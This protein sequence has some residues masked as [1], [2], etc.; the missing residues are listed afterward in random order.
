[1]FHA[2][3]ITKGQTSHSFPK[4]NYGRK[5]CRFLRSSRKRATIVG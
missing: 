1:M 2:D 5:F 4:A 3:F